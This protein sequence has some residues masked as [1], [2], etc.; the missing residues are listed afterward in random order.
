[1]KNE[2][3]KLLVAALSDTQFEI[4]NLHFTFFNS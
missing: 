1:M 3:F 2:N 4:L